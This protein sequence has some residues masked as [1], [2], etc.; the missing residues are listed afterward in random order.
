MKYWWLEKYKNFKIID[1]KELTQDINFFLTVPINYQ[2]KLL[3]LS[4]KEPNDLEEE[5][6]LLVLYEIVTNKNIK[7]NTLSLVINKLLT[8]Q[9]N[10]FPASDYSFKEMLDE[11]TNLKT[12]LPKEEKL[13]NNNIA[14]CYNCLNVYYIDKIKT[15]NKN[16]LCLC[17]FC[18]SHKL[19]FDNDYIPMNYTFIKLAYIYYHVSKLGCN[20]KNIQRILK[21]SITLIDTK[22]T[23]LDLTNS[24]DYKRIKPQEEKIIYYNIYKQLISFDN[25]LNREINIYIPG[26]KEKYLLIILLIVLMEVL[27]ECIYL[28]R[29]NIVTTKENKV[30]LNDLLKTLITY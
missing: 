24:F 28:K 17:P 10:S 1:I 16:K 26:L 27:S 21:N 5:D 23:D 9:D 4:N 25:E 19:Y 30:L 18:R 11:V 14:I 2:K 12:N 15:V 13:E 6:L 7:D 3:E 8:Y 22:K 20:F 29:I